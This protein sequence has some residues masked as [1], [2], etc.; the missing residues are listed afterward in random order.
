MTPDALAAAILADL[1]QRVGLR[2][3][4]HS[5]SPETLRSMQRDW[6]EIIEDARRE[7]YA[8]RIH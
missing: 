1:R 5:L 4:L 8:D 6:A 2:D 3:Y 7:M